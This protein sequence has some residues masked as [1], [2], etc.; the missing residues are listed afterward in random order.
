MSKPLVVVCGGGAGG[1]ELV[2]R[3]AARGDLDLVLVDRRATH[4]WKP[5][6]HELA[7][8]SLDPSD[9]E[10]SYLAL[11]QRYCFTFAHGWLDNVDRHHRVVRV[12]PVSDETG[13]EIIPA[14]DFHYDLAVIAI[15]GTTNNFGIKGVKE[16][17][18]MLDIP[19]DAE[20]IR[21]SI[22]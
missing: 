10:V 8:G 20:A 12:A 1:L 4:L 2:V 6:L 9:H 22:V 21:T 11:A 7:S 15:G 18:L 16:N 17:A 3:L 14:R 5:L 13:T 19:E